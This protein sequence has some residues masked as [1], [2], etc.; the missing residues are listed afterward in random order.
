M[1]HDTT[2]APTGGAV[3]GDAVAIGEPPLPEG[4]VDGIGET[5]EDGPPVGKLGP[6]FV[7]PDD[8]WK[9][10]LEPRGCNRDTPYARNATTRTIAAAAV[11]ATAGFRIC[12]KTRLMAANY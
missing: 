5:V 8:G 11:V 2:S 1:S 10:V 3:L 9:A 12:W 6:V 7:A 4:D